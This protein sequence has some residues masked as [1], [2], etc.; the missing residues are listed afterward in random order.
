[1]ARHSTYFKIV[2]WVLSVCP[3]VYDTPPAGRW[4]YAVSAALPENDDSIYNTP[5]VLPAHSNQGSEVSVWPGVICSC[6]N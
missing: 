1:M 4:Q 6:C 5:R 2:F 3:E